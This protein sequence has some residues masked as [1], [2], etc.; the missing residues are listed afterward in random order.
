LS[1]CFAKRSNSASALGECIDSSRSTAQYISLSDAARSSTLPDAAPA[2][3]CGTPRKDRDL[4]LRLNVRGG[5]EAKAA[6]TR[7]LIVPGLKILFI[8]R[9]VKRNDF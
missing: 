8:V 7:L 5:A 6:Q 9:N 3:A 2:S 4:A 1:S